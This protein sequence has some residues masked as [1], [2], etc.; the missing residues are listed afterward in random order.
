MPGPFEFPAVEELCEGVGCLD[1]AVSAEH[2]EEPE[3]G[4]SLSRFH[5]SAG[6]VAAD[7]PGAGGV[8]PSLVAVEGGG[9][10]RKGAPGTVS[11]PGL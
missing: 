9:V 8:E 5:I 3:D 2:D 10:W 1:P 6:A 7:P 11:R 4:L